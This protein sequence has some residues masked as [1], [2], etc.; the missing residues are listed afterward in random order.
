MGKNTENKGFEI[1]EKSLDSILAEVE[2]E[3]EPVLKAEKARLA[4]A[5]DDSDGP[6]KKDDKGGDDKGEKSGGDDKGPPKSDDSSADASAPPAADASASAPPAGPPA[7]PAGPPGADASASAPPA[8]SPPASPASPGF[9]TDPAALAQMIA[10]Q[11]L[12]AQKAIYLASKQA[13]AASMSAG[14]GSPAPAGAPA[15]APPPGPDASAMG[16]GAGAPPM[17]P[18]APPAGPPAGAPPADASGA[19]PMD[20]TMKSDMKPS[21]GNGGQMKAVAK[22]EKTVDNNK[23]TEELK[24]LVKSQADLIKSQGEK[25]DLLQRA[26]THIAGTPVRKAVTSVSALK[27][28]EGDGKESKQLTKAEMNAQ[29]SQMIKGGKLNKSDKEKVRKFYDEGST[30]FESIAHLFQ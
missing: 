1:D 9:P 15:G 14:A 17:A 6:P 19:P 3:L 27:K 8:G 28:T 12:E 24:K 21:E 13:L 29:L 10:A 16:P 11:P 30:N 5:D 26:V 18:P 20:P 23:D 25:L 7:P 4:K 2:Q 22:S